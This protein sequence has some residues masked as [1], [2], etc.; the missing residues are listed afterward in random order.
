MND[1]SR[2]KKKEMSKPQVGMMKDTNPGRINMAMR[3]LYFV[4]KN[5]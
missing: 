5:F 2:L 4:F 1:H 3:C